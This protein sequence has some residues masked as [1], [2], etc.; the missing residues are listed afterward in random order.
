MSREAHAPDRRG[1]WRPAALWPELLTPNMGKP[2]KAPIGDLQSSSPMS[3][4]PAQPQQIV[5]GARPS[6]GRIFWSVLITGLLAALPLW[7]GVNL[8]S[9]TCALGVPLST[10]V[11]AWWQPRTTQLSQATAN[12]EAPAGNS[13]SLQHLMARVLPVWHEHVQ[14]AQAQIDGAVGELI[15]NFASVTDQFEAA[16]FKG[17]GGQSAQ[18]GESAAMLALCE[19]QLQ[20]V[21]VLMGELSSTKGQVSA[22]MTE[23]LQATRDLQELAQGVAQIAAQTNLLAI[24]AAIEAAHAGDSGRGFAAVA[25]EIRSLSQLSADT[26]SQIKARIGEVTHIMQ[27]ASEAAVQANVREDQ[28]ISRSGLVVNDVLEHMRHLNTEAEAML[29]RGGVIRSHVEQLIM[30]LQFQDRVNQ[31][32]SVI[33]GDILRLQGQLD[34][35]L[36]TAEVWLADLKNKYTMREQRQSPSRHVGAANAAPAPGA[37]K[38][39]MF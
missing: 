25:K 34:R 2:S 30:S 26:A 31:V 10:F 6:A 1:W 23:M 19:Q 12:L 5:S 14:T 28:A 13:T 16:G 8:L 37:R 35:D 18:Q 20:E 9:V 21:V 11:L 27:G 24:N 29:A 4:T 7:S 39:I 17:A 36:P 15:T 33:D 38:V 32:I 3:G 22:S